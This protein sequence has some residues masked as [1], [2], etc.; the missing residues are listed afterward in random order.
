M[1]AMKL[2]PWYVRWAWLIVVVLGSLVALFGVYLLVVPVDTTDFHKVT[3]TEWETFSTES[4]DLA[5]YLEREAR[6][7][8]AAGIGLG[9]MTASL[10]G[11]LVRQGNR[12]AWW[13]LWAFPVTL[14][15]F[16]AVLL[17]DTALFLGAFYTVV[18]AI[19]FGAVWFAD[20]EY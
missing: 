9:A 7:L 1:R 15:L 6:L 10:A 8:G 19:A 11:S 14:G 17:I 2:L 13:L 16:A 12:T 5:G 3:D 20:P 4:P 18:A